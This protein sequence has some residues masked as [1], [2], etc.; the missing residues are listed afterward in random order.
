[1]KVKS[2]TDRLQECVFGLENVALRD[3][4]TIVNLSSDIVWSARRKYVCK[5]ALKKVKVA[6]DVS[7]LLIVLLRCFQLHRC[8]YRLLRCL[9]QWKPG[10]LWLGAIVALGL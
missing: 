3:A 8:M 5:G 2:I 9:N 7:C 10:L 4:R 6:A 1:M